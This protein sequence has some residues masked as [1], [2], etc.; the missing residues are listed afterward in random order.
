MN[1]KECNSDEIVFNDQNCEAVCSDCGLVQGSQDIYVNTNE[2]FGTDETQ[3]KYKTKPNNNKKTSI[4]KINNWYLT[5]SKERLDNKLKCNVREICNEL[6]ISENLVD[7]I[8]KLVIG[9]MDVIKKHEGTKRTRIKKCI[10]LLCISHT[11]RNSDYRVSAEELVKKM[12]IE[13]K[14]LNRTRKLILDLITTKKLI[15]DKSF[16]LDYS[17]P[18]QILLDIVKANNIEISDRLLKQTVSLLQECD[19]HEILT[20]NSPKCVVAS[21]LYYV[22]V[23]S[24][25][26]IDIKTFSK[27][28]SISV[29]TLTKNVNTLRSHS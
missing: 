25:I 15:M 16:V 2:N 11:C 19:T 17:S 26:D 28:T 24:S 1:C 20:S 7:N 6:K 9:V 18:E 4:D 10:I 3:I 29:P 8:N 5:T 22:L 12:G 13:V 14:F 23:R 27:I 21:C